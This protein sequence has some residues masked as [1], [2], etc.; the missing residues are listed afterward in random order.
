M[1]RYTPEQKSN[2]LSRIEEIGVAKTA[3]ELNI[4][5]QTL[6]KWRNEVKEIDSSEATQA[7]TK[8]SAAKDLLANDRNL[9]EQIE[10]LESQLKSS[11]AQNLRY[12]AAL[13]AL[14]DD[15]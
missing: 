15:N 11:R 3:E 7:V 10:S 4:S 9:Q 8:V 2:A 1:K 5:T 6:Y 12:R 14:L 13:A